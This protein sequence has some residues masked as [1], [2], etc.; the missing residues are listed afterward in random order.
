MK[1]LKTLSLLLAALTVMTLLVPTESHAKPRGRGWTSLGVV[2]F[3]GGPCA[4]IW[5]RKHWLWGWQIVNE[6]VGCPE[7][8]A[9]IHGSSTTAVFFSETAAFARFDAK[10]SVAETFGEPVSITLEPSEEFLGPVL[11]YGQ[12]E[13]SLVDLTA[14]G[15]EIASV[16]IKP[17]TYPE[18]VRVQE[19]HRVAELFQGGDEAA[20]VT[21]S[22]DGSNIEKVHTHIRVEPTE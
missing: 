4:E 2:G 9:P 7:R 15:E 22:E 18:S 21:V 12:E 14:E 20:L 6:P 16:H 5:T 8:R 11:T 1:A 13:A 17:Q 3:E 19:S 10:G